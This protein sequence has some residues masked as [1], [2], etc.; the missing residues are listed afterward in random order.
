M[1]LLDSSNALSQVDRLCFQRYNIHVDSWGDNRDGIS[2]GHYQV[3]VPAF[4]SV[5]DIADLFQQSA[6]QNALQ[7]R[8]QFPKVCLQRLVVHIEDS[9]IVANASKP[10]I[11]GFFLA[12]IE[13]SSLERLDAICSVKYQFRVACWSDNREG[14]HLGSFQVQIPA[15]SSLNQ[16]ADLLNEVVSANRIQSFPHRPGESFKATI[17]QFEESELVID[18]PK[19]AVYNFFLS[20]TKVSS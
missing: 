2:M 17:V 14:I 11:Y 19:P 9:E 3:T 8:C 12:G 6:L 1:N 4:S 7:F 15:F 5:S 16:T 10:A 13:L 20:G 18:A